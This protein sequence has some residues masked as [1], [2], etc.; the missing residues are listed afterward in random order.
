MSRILIIDDDQA[1]L[2]MLREVLEESDHLVL[3]ASNAKQGLKLF[4]ET[5]PDLVV[6]DIIMP[7]LDGFELLRR[8]KESGQN[9]KSVVLTGLNDERGREQAEALVADQYLVKPIDLEKFKGIIQD[10]LQHS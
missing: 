5:K 7:G 3:L 8:F 1:L 6:I 2:E 9:F 10:L 4:E